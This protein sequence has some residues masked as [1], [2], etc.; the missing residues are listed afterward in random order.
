MVGTVSR[1]SSGFAARHIGETDHFLDGPFLEDFDCF[2]Q[3][4]DDLVIVW[5]L[6]SLLPGF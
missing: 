1:Q 6:S 3:C 4:T 5:R 2:L